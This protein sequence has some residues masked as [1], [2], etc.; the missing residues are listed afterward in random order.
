M[1][2]YLVSL[3]DVVKT[4]LTVMTVRALQVQ[5]NAEISSAFPFARRQIVGCN[6]EKC[7]LKRGRKS[8]AQTML[9]PGSLARQCQVT[10]G[11]CGRCVR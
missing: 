1:N 9:L 7:P 3:E 4:E 10:A 8:S 2:A 6:L 5:G 11:P